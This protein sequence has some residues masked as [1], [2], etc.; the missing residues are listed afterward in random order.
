MK[1]NSTLFLYV[2]GVNK[3]DTIVIL[4][5][6]G[7]LLPQRSPKGYLR[8]FSANFSVYLPLWNFKNAKKGDKLK[9]YQNMALNNL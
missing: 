3:S 6:R 4:V 1:G 5:I 7:Q 8:P 9:I 2:C